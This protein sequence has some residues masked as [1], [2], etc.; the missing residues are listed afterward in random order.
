MAS[1][2]TPIDGRSEATAPE[3]RERPADPERA[4]LAAT[5]ALVV[6]VAIAAFAVLMP[7]VLLVDR[8]TALPPPF[9]AQNQD[10]ETLLYL[11]AFFVLLPLALVGAPRLADRI[12]RGPNGSAL[13]ALTALL[14][15]ALAGVVIAVKA[16]QRLHVGEGVGVVLVVAALWWVLAAPALARAAAPRPWAALL[17]AG[18]L[19][20]PAWA[21]AGVLLGGA[22]LCLADL[23]SISPLAAL[24]GVAVAGGAVLA[25]ARGWVPSPQRPWGALLDAAIVGLVLLAVPDLVIF[26]PEQ[27]PGNL[28]VGLETGIIQFHQNFLLGPA[29]QILHGGAMLVD[30][31]SQYGVGS[32]LVLVG[33]SKLAPIGYGTFGFLDGALTALWF[34]AGYAVLRLAGTSRAL[35]APT[36][37]VA[38][39]ALVFNLAYPVGALPQYGPLRFGLPMAVVLAAVAAER[40]PRWARVADAGALA[41]VGLSSVWSLESFAYT[42]AVFAALAGLRAWLRP[43]PGRARWLA[44]QAALAVLACA[45]A[46]AAFALVTLAATGH[47]PDWGQYLAYLR[48]FLFGEVG[49]LTY[50]V[51]PWSP[52]L[53]V[54]AGYLASAAA[55]VE[56]VRR[57][58][59]PLSVQRPT[60]VAIA[61]LTA[62]GIVLLSYF[63]NRSQDYVLMRVA[64]PGLLLGALWLGVLLRAGATV[65]RPARLGGLALSLGVAV[66]VLATAWSS[67]AGRFPRSALAHATPGGSSLRGAVHRL[68]HPPPLRPGADAG[69]RLMNRYLPGETRSLVMVAPDLGIEILLRS[70]RAD[71]LFLGDPV[72]ASFVFAERLPALRTVV[73]GLRPGDRMLMDADG[74]AVL[75]VLRARPSLDPLSRRA[76]AQLAPLQRWALK[77]IDERFRLR[78]IHREAGY[79][80]VELEPR[81]RA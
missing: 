60:L 42:V 61:G 39:V 8:P 40:R 50:D 38:V 45:I 76:P 65:P 21:A 36:L 5:L 49:N 56:L 69:T 7:V 16:L 77:R 66:L 24:A 43:G 81:L 51:A 18:A 32:V 68:W 10:A 26:R 35:S 44:R 55:I 6:I 37:A 47:I 52:S 78:T 1:S 13:L 67:V 74:R 79:S 46:Q 58:A 33:W 17:R 20:G 73:A 2:A 53:A 14:A 64:L 72:E 41:T 63:V 15:A 62:Y 3:P 4:P 23:G 31:A 57:R 54:G 34:A 9:P 25:V 70:D 48:A 30:T 71:R 27:A 75:A 29:N 12:F 80:V 28:A 11:L 59:P 22:L 19:T